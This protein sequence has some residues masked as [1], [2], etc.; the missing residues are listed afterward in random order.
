[1]TLLFICILALPFGFLMGRWSDR[2]QLRRLER[3]FAMERQAARS[4]EE[5]MGSYYA[6]RDAA[7]YARIAHMTLAEIEMAMGKVIYR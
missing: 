5:I 3:Q 2:I 4:Q 1:M 7:R 6:A